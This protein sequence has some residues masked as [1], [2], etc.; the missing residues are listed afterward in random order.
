MIN[1]LYTKQKKY[2]GQKT[3]RFTCV[4][5]KKEISSLDDL[6]K[7]RSCKKK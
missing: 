2:G 5:C 7:H 1:K 6:N 4:Y 3:G